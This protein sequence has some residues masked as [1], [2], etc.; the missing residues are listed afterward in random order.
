[1]PARI[2]SVKGES[3]GNPRRLHFEPG[4]RVDPGAWRRDVRLQLP[5]DV[6]GRWA[7]TRRTSHLATAADGRMVWV[8]SPP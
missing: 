7:W 3:I 2:G 1:M 5:V 6:L 8:P 4:G